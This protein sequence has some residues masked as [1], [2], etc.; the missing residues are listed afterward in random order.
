[1]IEALLEFGLHVGHSNC[2]FL[3]DVGSTNH[4]FCSI[5]VIKTCIVPQ[6]KTSCEK[7]YL[8]H[9]IGN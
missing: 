3:D 1:M 7:I 4:V 9:M 8:Q 6:T 5:P 2:N